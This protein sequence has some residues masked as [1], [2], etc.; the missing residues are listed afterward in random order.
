MARATRNTAR[1]SSRSR[2][3]GGRLAGGLGIGLALVLAL[4]LAGCGKS[5]YAAYR[6]AHPEWIPA[7]PESEDT[8]ERTVASLYAPAKR[9]NQLSVQ[10]LQIL[11]VDTEPWQEIP[12]AALRDGSFESSDAHSYLV[13][14]DLVCRAEYD[15]K[16]FHGEKITWYLLPGNRVAAYDHY[17]FVEAC[18]S[19]SEFRRA[20]ASDE[21]A[22]ALEKAAVAHVEATFPPS[23]FHVGDL[24]RKGVALARA[25]RLDEAEALL[26][27]GEGAMDVTSGRLPQFEEPGVPIRIRDPD[28][29]RAWLARLREAI[30]EE[31]EASVEEGR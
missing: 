11:R 28:Q 16:I 10:R 26:A 3:T 20:E 4:S 7:F 19:W 9:G 5:Y 6:E 18:T 24:M 31:R 8:L 12:F 15:L 13:V 30:A 1:G 25:G 29:A 27:S 22:V 2:D 14:A 17:E 23:M 21:E